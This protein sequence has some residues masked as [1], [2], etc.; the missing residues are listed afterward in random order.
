MASAR[1]TCSIA[2]ARELCRNLGDE[3]RLK[4]AY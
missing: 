1:F 4:A 3:N 2:A